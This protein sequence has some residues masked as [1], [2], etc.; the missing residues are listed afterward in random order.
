MTNQES[1]RTGLALEGGAL[2]GLFSMGFVDVM[3]T[4]GSHPDVARRRLS[5]PKTFFRP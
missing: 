4:H 5:A 1:T 2:R 3:T